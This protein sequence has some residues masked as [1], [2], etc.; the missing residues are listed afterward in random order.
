MLSIHQSII[1]DVLIWES[2]LRTIADGSSHSSFKNCTCTYSSMRTQQ[3]SLA[4]K[5][6]K[7]SVPFWRRSRLTMPFRFMLVY[8]VDICGDYW[9]FNAEKPQDELFAI[10]KINTKN[11]R[12]MKQV[13]SV[14]DL[15]TAVVRTTFFGTC[16]LSADRGNCNNSCSHKQFTSKPFCVPYK[17]ISHWLPNELYN[18]SWLAYS[19][20][21]RLH[22]VSLRTS[23]ESFVNRTY[24]LRNFLFVRTFLWKVL[25]IPPQ[26]FRC[27]V[28]GLNLK[29][30]VYEASTLTIRPHTLIMDLMC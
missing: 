13:S 24:E 3:C 27:H 7:R 25:W 20:L 18:T 26:V 17:L 19:I 10:R 22:I 11:S 21:G 1:K 30:L 4:R 29:L 12:G 15:Y 23:Y 16:E 9:S 6:E 2:I 8:L 5:T 14:S 28:L